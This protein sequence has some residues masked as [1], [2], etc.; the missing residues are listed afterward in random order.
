MNKEFLS[1]M[2]ELGKEMDKF[3]CTYRK[4]K[5]CRIINGKPYCNA[6]VIARNK[7]FKQKGELLFKEL[8]GKG[9]KQ[10]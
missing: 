8:L 3:D 4:K 6:L 2:K 7:S 9:V 5:N 10:K 1:K